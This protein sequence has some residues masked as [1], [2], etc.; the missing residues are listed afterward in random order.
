MSSPDSWQDGFSVDIV[1]PVEI[2]FLLDNCI[3][4]ALN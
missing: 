3:K 1:N 4:A 2:K